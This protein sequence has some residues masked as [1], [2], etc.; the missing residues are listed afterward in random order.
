M[1]WENEQTRLACQS[2][3][4]AGGKRCLNILNIWSCGGGSCGRGSATEGDQDVDLHK[5]AAVP[6]EQRSLHY[7]RILRKHLP[8]LQCMFPFG[9]PTSRE[10][11]SMRKS[12][13]IS[14]LQQGWS[15]VHTGEVKSPAMRKYQIGS[16]KTSSIFDY[17]DVPAL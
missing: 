7:W 5:G 17:F 3:R 15:R 14:H 11:K 12:Q 9:S 10:R 16:L 6:V 1:E 4:S 2:D 8:F 13:K